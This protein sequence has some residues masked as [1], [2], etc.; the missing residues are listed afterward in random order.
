M[1]SKEIWGYARVST[2][3]QNLER[4]LIELRQYVKKEE[5]IFSDKQSGKDFNR[6]AYQKLKAVARSGDEIY[7]KNIYRLGRNK[8]LIKDELQ[9]FKNKG[10]HVH[11]LNFPQTMIAV[12]DEHQKSIMELVT[13]LL[14]EVFSFMAEE[15]RKN[16][17]ARQAEGIAVWRKTRKTKTGRPYGRPRAQLPSNWK[18]IY[19]IWKTK[20]IK[21]K[22]AWQLLK[23]SKNTFYNFVKEHEQNNPESSIT[24]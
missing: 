22:E 24:K 3:E 2:K 15:E 20:K 14:I 13:N 8:E 12:E 7:V 23:V 19:E 4:Q 11:I 16:I 5:N 6:D 21:S 9:Y 17:R 18:N 10:I 1:M